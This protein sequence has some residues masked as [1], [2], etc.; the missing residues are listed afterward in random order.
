MRIALRG[1]SGISK[2]LRRT[3]Q[4]M[5]SIARTA[6]QAASHRLPTDL[7]SNHPQPLWMTG[8]LVG[9]RGPVKRGCISHALEPCGRSAAPPRDDEAHARVKRRVRARAGKW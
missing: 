3:G 7:S 5:T 2:R 1:S 8:G 9:H 4:K 6:S